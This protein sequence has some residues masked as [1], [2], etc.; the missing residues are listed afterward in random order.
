MG[1]VLDPKP[2]QWQPKPHLEQVP[3]D[4]VLFLVSQLMKLINEG[5]TVSTT[6]VQLAALRLVQKGIILNYKACMGTAAAEE[7][8]RQ[9]SELARQYIIKGPDGHEEA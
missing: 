4:H 1:D 8:L 6:V 5:Q 2:P 9:A 3:D 7:A